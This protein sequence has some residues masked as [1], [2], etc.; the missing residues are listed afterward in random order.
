MFL[1]SSGKILPEYSIT[2]QKTVLF[3]V[4]GWE[5][6]VSQEVDSFVHFP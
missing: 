5:P 2:S 4:T 3:T 1:Q 6:Q